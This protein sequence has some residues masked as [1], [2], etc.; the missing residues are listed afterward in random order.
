MPKFG[1][2]KF[3]T[4]KFG[5]YT[6]VIVYGAAGKYLIGAGTFSSQGFTPI[7]GYGAQHV[8]GKDMIANQAL[9]DAI[10]RQISSY[11]LKLFI[12]DNN[13]NWV[14]FSEYA[15]VNGRNMLRR[16]GNISSNSERLQ[17]SVRQR[18]SN[19]VLDN[20]SGF[21]NEPFP[22]SLYASYDE[23]WNWLGDQS[24]SASFG[25]SYNNK[26]N[27]L[28][29]HKLCIKANY[30]L[31]GTDTTEMITL[32]TFLIDKTNADLSSHAFSITLTSLDYPL[33]EQDASVVKNGSD[34]YVNRPI[35]YLVRELVKSVYRGTDGLL[36]STYDVDEIVNY[37][38]PAV[39]NTGWAISHTGRPP[40]KLYT[41]S[42]SQSSWS[43]SWS[44]NEEHHRLAKAIC[45]HEI[46]IGTLTITAG[47]KT[48]E[49]SGGNLSSLNAYQMII[50][51]DSLT[52][53]RSYTSGDGGSDDHFGHYTVASVDTTNNTITLTEPVK[54]HDDASGIRWAVVRI[55]IGVGNTLYQYNQAEDAYYEMVDTSSSD[56]LDSSYTIQRLWY[57]SADSSW[58]IYG[59]ALTGPVEAS[60]GGGHT[61]QIFRA[62][63]NSTSVIPEFEKVGSEISNVMNAEF[64]K[65]EAMKGETGNSTWA[66]F[67]FAGHFDHDMVGTADDKDSRRP[68]EILFDQHISNRNDKKVWANFMNDDKDD[69]IEASEVTDI[70]TGNTTSNTYE[71][72]VSDT[73]CRRGLY[74]L[75]WDQLDDAGNTNWPGMVRYSYGQE[76]FLLL[77]VDSSWDSKGSVIYAKHETSDGTYYGTV[78]GTPVHH[79]YRYDITSGSETQISMGTTWDGETADEH[80]VPICGYADSTNGNIYIG[81]ATKTLVDETL[82]YTH[83][84]W[85]YNIASG[86]A[87]LLNSATTYG[88]PLEYEMIN[89]YLWGVFVTWDDTTSGV[90]NVYYR[91]CA[92]NSSNVLYAQTDATT[93]EIHGLSSISLDG[94][95]TYK[96]M[97]IESEAQRLRTIDAPSFTGTNPSST[98]VE[99]SG[100]TDGE[101]Y[102]LSNVCVMDE[103]TQLMWISSP[104]PTFTNYR[105]AQG[106]FYLNQWSYT[107]GA[108]IELADF[109]D[110]K[111][112]DAIGYIAD[113][114]NA[115][116]GFYPDGNFFFKKKP[117]HLYSEH[118]FTNVGDNQIKNIK[119]DAGYGEIVNTATRSPH[120]ITIPPP[121]VVWDLSPNSKYDSDGY[122]HDIDVMR[123]TMGSRSIKLICTQGG[124]ISTGLNDTSGEPENV[125]VKFKYEVVDASIE[126]TLL[127]NLT[128]GSFDY[129]L[130][131]GEFNVLYG[132]SVRLS[133]RDQSQVASGDTTPDNIWGTGKLGYKCVQSGYAV[134]LKYD[135]SPTDQLI[136]FELS[137]G[138]SVNFSS[139]FSNGVT[140]AVG[141][142]VVIGDLDNGTSMEYC[143]VVDIMGT[144]LLLKRASIP[145][146]GMMTSHSAGEGMALIRNGNAY[147]VRDSSGDFSENY[148]SGWSGKIFEIGD[149]VVIDLPSSGLSTAQPADAISTQD[150]PSVHANKEFIP[151]DDIYMPVGGDSSSI[152]TGVS[153]K[154]TFGGSRSKEPKFSVGD[155]V[156]IR[157]PGLTLSKDATITHT[158]T[159]MGSVSTYTKR[160]ARQFTDNPFLNDDDARWIVRRIVYDNRYPCYTITLYTLTMPWLQP[161]KVITIQS[162]EMFPRAV[163][164]KVEAYVSSI[165]FNLQ[166]DGLMEMVCRSIKPY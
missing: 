156:R 113:K 111:A 88:I 21:F 120:R 91:V 4:Q 92:Y 128:V 72:N 142:E 53:P 82:P 28:Y 144:S 104:A 80:G 44:W 64:Y 127:N 32:G 83:K 148:E 71:Q 153:L 57:N 1:T 58:P 103:T 42:S 67:N 126:T 95:S 50:A 143:Q 59:A 157:A 89:N 74:S 30:V 69:E 5:D 78:Y 63:I 26:M 146:R 107:I 131:D 15:E 101:P 20:S 84:T 34:W 3:G 132:S 150:D 7:T 109:S 76:G 105:L 62:H 98:I 33:A 94:G 149:R 86:S 29:R 163:E 129:L 9:K 145:E 14:D 12:Q 43:S 46:T 41:Y 85:K 56:A 10:K 49:V 136:E 119:V 25:Y 106:R 87:S 24:T 121:Q 48:V 16:I 166:Y 19:I 90:S 117:R 18:V 55:Y 140:M 47:S 151:V 51:G 73:W 6:Q 65:E 22:A 97:Y 8:E 35:S 141:T 17:G 137:N 70:R 81:C 125:E 155:V 112:W 45:A 158:Y 164:H 93:S 52:I 38:V 96:C 13:Y 40:E 115:L 139:P 165:S 161:G 37:D 2:F 162:P 61:M 123:Y 60:A 66:T 77:I 99:Y 68:M 11:E 110:M 118:T 54:G 134:Q 75:F 135:I 159:D 138:T 79:Y 133:G 27:I 108:R 130:L 160:D 124:R 100:F 147:F 152:Y 23:D 102:S 39:D 154:F 116:Y 114:A 122:R 36:P 31:T